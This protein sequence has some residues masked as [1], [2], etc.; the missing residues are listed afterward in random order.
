[1]KVLYFYQHFTTPSIGGGTRAYEFAKRLKERG[2]SVTIVC[3]ETVQLNLPET[4][5]KGIF[6]GKVDGIDVIQIALPYSNR[7]GIAQRAWTFIKFGYQ[8]VK[9]AF[10]KDY[11]ILFATSTPLTAG[12]PG[13]I[14]KW[15]KKKKFV[16]EV[17]DLWP[18]LPKAL[19]MKNPF[20][21]SG[22]G[23]LEKL[24]YKYA[25]ACI[26]LSPGICEGI[27]RRSP[28]SKPIIFIPNSCDLE[29]FKPGNRADL[30]LEGIK[31]TDTVAVFTGAHGVA[32]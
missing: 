15:F 29:I 24:S 16:F 5:T 11:D 25:D 28:K 9:L 10:V 14:M 31:P 21:L 32:N 4:S 12:I 8:G 7:D 26:G 18:E 30:K 17:R 22:M 1:M 6:S 19:G 23:F 20:L 27:A 13:I 2:H 3:G